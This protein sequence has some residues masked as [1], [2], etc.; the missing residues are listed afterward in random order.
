MGAVDKQIADEIE[1]EFHHNSQ[2][3][4]QGY[5]HTQLPSR[6]HCDCCTYPAL[7]GRLI[8]HRIPYTQLSEFMIVIL[9]VTI[10][11]AFATLY[12]WSSLS[13]HPFTALCNLLGA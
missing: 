12:C 11:Q 10:G 7:N 2:A 9:W 8:R 5:A 6:S 4:G 3:M 13:I 1:A